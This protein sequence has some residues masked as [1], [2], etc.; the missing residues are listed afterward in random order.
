[1]HL[2]HSTMRGRQAL[3]ELA[4]ALPD[5]D[6]GEPDEDGMFEIAVDADDT[7]AALARVWQGVAASGADEHIVF[8]E[9]SNLPEHWRARG[10]AG[11]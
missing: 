6:V 11:S 3:S 5:A 9:H 10:E 2:L 1:M 4:Q 8:V 7:E